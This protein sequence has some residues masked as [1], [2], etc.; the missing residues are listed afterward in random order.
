MPYTVNISKETFWNKNA[1]IFK[2]TTRKRSKNNELLKKMAETWSILKFE[3]NT[4][5]SP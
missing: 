5:T 3:P 4:F 2:K 1:K